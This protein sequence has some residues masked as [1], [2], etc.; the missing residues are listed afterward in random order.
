MVLKES[1]NSTISETDAINNL[2]QTNVS[3]TIDTGEQNISSTQGITLNN[4]EEVIIII[5]SNYTASNVYIT[6]PTVNSS[7]Y[8][9]TSSSVSIT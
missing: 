8:N 9:D 2:G 3:W 5:E 1:Q 4:T 7:S 6:K